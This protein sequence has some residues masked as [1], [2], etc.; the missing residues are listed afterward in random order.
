MVTSMSRPTKHFHQLH[1]GRKF[2]FH[3]DSDEM[4][5]AG[6]FVHL[7]KTASRS[8]D[9]LKYLVAKSFQGLRSGYSPTL[10][11]SG[12]G[13]TYFMHDE[14]NRTIGVFKP[15]DEEMWCMNNPKGFTPKTPS[16]K[17]YNASTRGAEAGEAA[18]REYAAYL[19]DHENFSGVPATG[20]VVCSHPAFSS[21]ASLN[22]HLKVGSFQEFKEHDFDTEDISSMKYQTFPVHEVHKIAILDIR[23]LNTDRHG[24]NI[25]V[26]VNRSRANSKD[27]VFSDYDSSDDDFPGG[28]RNRRQEDDNEMMF[29]MDMDLDEDEDD[30]EQMHRSTT[31]IS[32]PTNVEYELIPIDHGY[33]LPST[34]SGLN[35]LWFEWL[36]WPQAKIPFGPESQRYI[37]RL[38]PDADV[39]ILRHKFGD[40]I[41]SECFKVLR[42]TTTWL[43]VASRVGLT[44]YTIGYALCRKSTEVPSTLEKMCLEAQL[45]TDKQLA[46]QGSPSTPN[47]TPSTSSP[48]FPLKLSHPTSLVSSPSSRPR[49]SSLL[50]NT[51][52][53]ETV[54]SD[55]SD[56]G[57]E[58]ADLPLPLPLPSPPPVKMSYAEQAFIDNLKVVMDRCASELLRTQSPPSRPH[59]P[60]LHRK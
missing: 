18:F 32:S 60:A 15:H 35:D 59:T 33:T 40:L 1:N 41:G 36:K 54:D 30:G 46:D 16:F 10:C 23:L 5:L 25:L 50:V 9:H 45:L 37:D 29:R 22:E 28:A 12:V 56:L 20:L 34:L 55:S 58:G 57:G 21:G 38:D 53:A 51:T 39:T 4:H 27:D 47:N 31:P 17:E 8:E 7:A 24:G 6:S 44:P 14:Y 49:E 3:V 48:S 11:E 13:G 43:K 52:T 42:I 26:K 19:L 2:S